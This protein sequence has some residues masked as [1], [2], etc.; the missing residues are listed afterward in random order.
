VT[1]DAL[2][3]VLAGVDLE[4]RD[5]ELSGKAL[6]EWATVNIETKLLPKG[7]DAAARMDK[8]VVR[9]VESAKAL[10]RGRGPG[11]QMRGNRPVRSATATDKSGQAVEI[12]LMLDPTAAVTPTDMPLRLHAFGEGAKGAMVRVIHVPT[13]EEQRVIAND[14]GIAWVHV[15][16]T[17]EYRLAF[18][19]AAAFVP[20]EGDASKAT[21]ALHSATCT[22]TVPA[23]PRAE[24]PVEPVKGEEEKSR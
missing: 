9:R 11:E 14:K 5:E 4:A 21:W 15:E 23:L 1:V 22:F 18:H 6:A 17:G 20:Q 13:G 3:A 10:W 16:R 12:R 19:A 2:D 8:V 24:P 7:F